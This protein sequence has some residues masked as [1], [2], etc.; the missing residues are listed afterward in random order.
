MYIAYLDESHDKNH[1]V[2]SALIIHESQ[3]NQVFDALKEFRKYLKEKYKIPLSRELH[4]RE[5]AA[6]RG[7]LRP[8][9]KGSKT[10]HLDVHKRDRARIFKLFTRGV[11][12]KLDRYGVKTINACYKM[13]LGNAE[14]KAIEAVLN[15]LNR[16][17]KE[18]NDH[19]LVVFDKGLETFH[20]KLYRKLRIYNPI[21]SKYG[22]WEDG[23]ATKNI[24]LDK[25]IA[26]PFFHDSSHDYF[27]Q[28]VDFIAFSLLKLEDPTPPKWAIKG[29]I[30]KAF[31]HFK[32]II[33]YE[34]CKKDKIYGVVGRCD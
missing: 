7:W 5:L 18:K 8:Y 12:G 25:I 11:I 21:P 29:K 2:V 23:R 32:K 30:N 24:T 14:E 27:I 19:M 10:R 34:A 3:W 28:A 9:G 20:R 22:M 16:F 31:D 1:Y 15:R 33:E 4:A 6:G 17:V 26:D 13:S